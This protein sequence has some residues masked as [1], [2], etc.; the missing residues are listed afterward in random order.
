[1]D[2]ACDSAEPPSVSSSSVRVRGLLALLQSFRRHSHSCTCI[3]PDRKKLLLGVRSCVVK[4]PQKASRRW[5]WLRVV[6]AR[7]SSS[8]QLGV[9][10]AWLASE[11][12][13]VVAC[14]LGGVG[15]GVGTMGSSVGMVVECSPQSVMEHV[16]RCDVKVET[17][18][19]VGTPGREYQIMR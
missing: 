1:M 11:R 6:G 2:L 9:S 5:T 13:W 8:Q 19:H 4:V 12:G 15:S 17:I 7:N 10:S 3:A 18:I 14:K 16:R